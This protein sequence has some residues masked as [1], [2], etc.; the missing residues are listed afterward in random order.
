MFSLITII[1]PKLRSIGRKHSLGEPTEIILSVNYTENDFEYSFVFEKGKKTEKESISETGNTE[2][3]E[4]FITK[5]E[6]QFLKNF[7]ETKIQLIDVKIDIQ[8]KEMFTEVYYLS[9]RDEFKQ[10]FLQQEKSKI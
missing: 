6:K 2:F 1:K 7:P 3:R 10:T 9:P 4:M 5:V 8:T